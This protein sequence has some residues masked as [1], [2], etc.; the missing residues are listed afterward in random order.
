[1]FAEL[2]NGHEWHIKN[3]QGIE[4]SSVGT[5]F[6]GIAGL[7][8]KYSNTIFDYSVSQTEMVLTYFSNSIDQVTIG[9][10]WYRQLT[11]P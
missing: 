4:V 10:F 2:S 9:Y 1:M 3:H 8:F 5:I 7:D 11:C 6:S